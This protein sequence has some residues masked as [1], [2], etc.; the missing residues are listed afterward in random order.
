MDSLV[1][2]EALKQLFVSI[3][4]NTFNCMYIF[5]R[6]MSTYLKIARERNFSNKVNG[7][8]FL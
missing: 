6:L 4:F 8:K 5:N 3:S 1:K 7:I 2:N